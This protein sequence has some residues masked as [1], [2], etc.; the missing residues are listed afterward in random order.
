MSAAD[1]WTQGNEE[2]LSAAL[3]WLRLRFARRADGGVSVSVAVPSPPE[4]APTSDETIERKRRRFRAPPAAAPDSGAEQLIALPPASE[5][6][7]SEAEAE[8]AAAMSAAEAAMDIPPALIILSQR[9][10]LTRF[11]QDLLLL[12]VATELDPRVPALCGHAQADARMAYPTFALAFNLFDEATWKPVLPDRPLRQF[13]LIEIFQSPGTPLTASALRA[14]ERVVSFVKGITYLDDRLTPLLVSLDVAAAADDD[15]PPSHQEL[16]DRILAE[17]EQQPP[18]AP[19]PVVQLLGPDAVTKQL[20]ARQVSDALS[21]PLYRLPSELLPRDPAELERLA[22]LWQR[23][24]L[25][26]PAALYLDGAG[27]AQDAQPSPVARLLSRSAGPLTFVDTTDVLHPYGRPNVVVDV[28]RPTREEQESAWQG[29]LGADSPEVAASLAGQFSLN[30]TA[31]QRI[32]AS[33]R[34]GPPEQPFAERVWSG[35]LIETRRGLDVLAQRIDAKATWD[36]IVLPE[37]QLHLLRRIA[38]QVAQRSRVY[39]T[40]GFARKTARGLGINALFAG[41]SGTG[42]TMAAEVIANDLRLNLYRIDLSA[43][44]NK[45]IGETEKNLARLFEGAE[46]GGA[47]LFFDE[48]D[49]L[50]GKRTEIRDSHDRYANIEINYLLQRM[51]AYQGLAI[52]ATN[53]KSALDSAFVRRLRFVVN[54]PYPSLAERTL[55]WQ[56]VFPAEAQTEQLDYERLGKLNFSGGNVFT[57]AMNAAFLAAQAGT[58]IT[59]AHVLESARA[60]TRKLDLPVNEH[61]FEDR[62]KAVSA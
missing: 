27:A 24:S 10:G 19:S 50:F 26:V 7:A 57:V 40:W 5:P 1:T 21:L 45:Y 31:I 34:S 38:D 29:T 4:V 18:D 58:P 54:F 48:A 32:A 11:E 51:E 44:V 36:D 8:A 12:C 6:S 15:P 56:R 14:D 16:V 42:K 35:A 30:V 13:S 25:L 23:E 59:M 49:A 53:M 47:V 60:E 3:R 61:D 41:P 43:V 39:E 55:I 20:V 46:A 62:P 9:F 28:Q 52:L 33:A 2:Y 17:L 22:R 37:A